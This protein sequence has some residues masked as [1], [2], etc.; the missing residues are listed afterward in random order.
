MCNPD[1]VT[2]FVGASFMLFIMTKPPSKSDAD[3]FVS[4]LCSSYKN[5]EMKCNFFHSIFRDQAT[6]LLLRT[7]V[8]RVALTQLI[9]RVWPCLCLI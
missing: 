9:T 7:E 6:A 2:M 4:Q 3:I 5:N 1:F 8:C